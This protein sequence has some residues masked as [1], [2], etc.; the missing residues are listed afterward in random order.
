MSKKD[1]ILCIK[2]LMLYLNTVTG[3]GSFN[4]KCHHNEQSDQY[5]IKISKVK[6][7]FGVLSCATLFCMLIKLIKKCQ[8]DIKTLH[9]TTI[10]FYS[11]L[12]TVGSSATFIILVNIMR[13]KNYQRTYFNFANLL[14]HDFVGLR[15]VISARQKLKKVEFVLCSTFVASTVL[16]LYYI[17]NQSFDIF[18]IKEMISLL[19]AF[20][21]F[22]FIADWMMTAL[23]Y[24]ALLVECYDSIKFWLDARRKNQ[25]TDITQELVDLQ[26]YYFYLLR[27]L[28]E[29]G[30]CIQF[31]SVV[32]L[33]DIT[34][35]QVLY[36]MVALECFYFGLSVL[37]IQWICYIIL[38]NFT[39]FLAIVFVLIFDK[40]NVETE[41]MVSYLQRFP[42]SKLK[43]RE[44]M[45]IVSLIKVFQ[46]RKPVIS[47]YDLF[48][49]GI[50]IVA[51]VKFY[52]LVFF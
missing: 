38:G 37:N 21:Y 31:C 5:Y 44:S 13:I 29:M 25:I 23:F 2:K 36:G 39:D 17:Y 41:K 10:Y 48:T 35:N 42:I 49:I 26:K 6:I 46:L 50:G 4:F 24:N 28:L 40:M 33:I 12:V 7:F 30:K 51:T 27:T 34:I 43:N 16:I 1:C 19:A 32:A 3:S 52:Y 8:S 9:R 14:R 45:Q 15:H 20:L 47:V 22:P 11:L 18:H